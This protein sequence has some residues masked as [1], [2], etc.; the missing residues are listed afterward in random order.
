MAKFCFECGKSIQPDWKVCPECGTA[1][2]GAAKVAESPS[3]PT[4]QYQQPYPR[5]IQKKSSREKWIKNAWIFTVVA[6]IVGTLSLLAPYA[7][8]RIYYSGTLLISIDY[9][10]YGVRS[11]YIYGYGTETYG[12][13]FINELA[14]AYVLTEVITFFIVI[15]LN[16][17]ALI[18]GISLRK[19]E[20]KFSSSLLGT[21]IGIVVTT[22]IFITLLNIIC[23]TMDTGFPYFAVL[24]VGFPVIWQFIG[25]GLIITGYIIGKI[26]PV[27]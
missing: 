7:Y 2:V 5:P 1:I 8:A 27:S 19:Q 24:D 6:T 9:W 18:K 14:A 3:A 15:S 21:A 13:E 20:R 26:K 23:I 22:I 16:L 4:P 12:W 11:F 17:Y 25:A 10:W